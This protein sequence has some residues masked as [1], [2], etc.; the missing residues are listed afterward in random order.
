MITAATRED[1]KVCY[2]P[3]ARH[4]HRHCRYQATHPPDLG[5]NAL[6]PESRPRGFIDPLLENAPL[7]VVDGTGQDGTLRVGIVPVDRP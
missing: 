1:E 4:C 2:A 3:S 6:T 7:P 5:V